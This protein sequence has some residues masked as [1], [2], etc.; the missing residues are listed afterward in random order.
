MLTA[1]HSVV[2]EAADL[3][4]AIEAYAGLLDGWTIERGAEGSAVFH[5][6][7]VRL[8]LRRRRVPEAASPGHSGDGLVALRL[9]ARVGVDSGSGAGSGASRRLGPIAGPTVPLEIVAEEAGGI[10]AP[11]S[12]P[13]IV[14]LDHVVVATGHPE[15][16]RA[17]LADE[18]G[19]RLALDRSFPERGLRLLFFRL[20]GVTLELAAALAPPAEAGDPAT[21]GVGAGADAGAGVG[22]GGARDAF[23]GLAWKVEDLAATHAR[24]AAAGLALSKIRPGHKSGTR[25]CSLHAPLYGVPT[26]LI[27]HPPR[28]DEAPR[29]GEGRSSQRH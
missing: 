6:G 22:V 13:G 11:P 27:E 25:V 8:E 1:I 19:I 18:L 17:F 2:L 7:G 12:G 14:G 10:G 16:T 3:E 15:R 26:L 28:S 21:V 24:L 5:A 29:P 23:H 20:G 9:A 4:G